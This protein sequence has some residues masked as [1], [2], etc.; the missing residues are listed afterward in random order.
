MTVKKYK[1]TDQV[2]Y[3]L[4]LTLTIE[5]LLK[6]PDKVR[7]VYLHSTINKNDAYYKIE[8][9]CQENNIPFL[10]SD[11]PF[12]ILS[13]KENCYVIGEFEKFDKEIEKDQNHVVLVNPSNAGNLGTIIRTAVGFGINNIAIIK[14]AVDIFDPKVIRA[15]MGALFHLNFEYYDS[16]K[17]YNNNISI[18][19]LYPFM[20]KG[21][22][23]LSDLN[24]KGLYSLIFGNEATGLSDDYLEYGQSIIIKHTNNIDS[25]NLPIAVSIALYQATKDTFN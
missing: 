16:F 23:S 19:E 10:Q 8:D 5:L 22:I 15:S 9:L 24:P 17:D 1:K 7:N 2:S 14:P 4:G 13:N 3:T 20:L 11:K 18:R 6:K 25:L 21:S 12:N